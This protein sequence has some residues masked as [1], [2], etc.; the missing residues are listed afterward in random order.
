MTEML[1]RAIGL[2]TATLILASLLAGCRPAASEAPA[3]TGVESKA[4]TPPPKNGKL[5]PLTIIAYN[6]TDRYID[7]V[8]A[9]GQG[10]GNVDLSDE[11]AGGSGGVCCIG[12][13]SGT[14]LPQKVK[15]RW[16]AGGCM[17]SITNQFG[18]RFDRVRHHFKEKEVLL[19]GPIPTK[20]HYF[21]IHIYPDNDRVEVGVTE[22]P[23]EPRLKLDE[24]RKVDAY[25]ERCKEEKKS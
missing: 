8:Y 23:S 18:E 1:N 11:Y 24:A 4:S 12:W 17:T 21:E 15:V 2:M 3:P 7:Q 19:Q 5:Y 13:R 16:V 25:P 9:D 14:P 20:P 10:G 6:Y 22:F